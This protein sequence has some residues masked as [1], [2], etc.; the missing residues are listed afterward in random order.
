V[1]ITHGGVASGDTIMPSILSTSTQVV[2]PP[3]FNLITEFFLKLK[4]EKVRSLQEFEQKT[5]ENLRESY[6]RM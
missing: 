1:S 6:I 5:N 4:M 2:P 3:L